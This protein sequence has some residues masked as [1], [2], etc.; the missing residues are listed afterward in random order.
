[1]TPAIQPASKTPPDRVHALSQHPMVAAV[2][3]KGMDHRWTHKELADVLSLCPR[4][5]QNAA[6][7]NQIP[8]MAFAPGKGKSRANRRARRFSTLDIV[9]FLLAS[10]E[11]ELSDKDALEIL[12]R[13]I[14]HL[15]TPWLVQVAEKVAA[16]IRRRATSQLVIA[17]PAPPPAPSARLLP[18]DDLFA[19]MSA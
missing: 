13:L 19:S 17:A 11:G 16:I 2:L 15:P 5:V 3:A 1:M 4:S 9:L 10:Y 14:S 18:A 6:E 12:A 7:T 8:H